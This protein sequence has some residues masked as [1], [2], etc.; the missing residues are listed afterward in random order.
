MNP[1]IAIFCILASGQHIQPLGYYETFP[2]CV[3]H[4]NKLET[5]LLLTQ[6][7]KKP[8]CW[9]QRIPIEQARRRPPQPK[10]RYSIDRK[11]PL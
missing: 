11:A 1:A 5:D 9:C 10:I 2:A 6:G 8:L 7:D 4:A 3:V